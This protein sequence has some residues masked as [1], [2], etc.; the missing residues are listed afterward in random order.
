MMKLRAQVVEQGLSLPMLR[1]MGHEGLDKQFGIESLIERVRILASEGNGIAPK[2]EGDGVPI[3][4]RVVEN[5]G[6]VKRIF[7]LTRVNFLKI[8]WIDP[9]NQSFSAHVFIEC[10]IRGGA[11][12]EHLMQDDDSFQFPY[13]SAKWFWRQ[14][15]DFSNSISHE[16]VETKVARVPPDSDDL[17]FQLRVIGTFSETLE[18]RRFPLDVQDRLS[19]SRS[20]VRRRDRYPWRSNYQRTCK[21]P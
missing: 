5:K 12:D 2:D 18:L 10:V 11:L 4:K 7:E 8:S 1:A 3:A 19:P 13:P 6:K 16:V 21:L 14:Q 20:S 17:T 15:V 9:I